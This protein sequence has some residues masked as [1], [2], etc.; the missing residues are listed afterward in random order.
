M[1]DDLLQFG[2]VEY[3]VK[4]SQRLGVL[5][6]GV[7]ILLIWLGMHV[8]FILILGPKGLEE[9]TNFLGAELDRYGGLIGVADVLLFLVLGSSITY[10]AR[11]LWTYR[12]VLDQHG[13]SREG[14]W[15]P[16]DRKI[17]IPYGDIERIT[18]GTRYVLRIIPRQGKVLAINVKILEEAS[19]GLIANLRARVGSGIVNTDLE[20]AILSKQSRDKRE[21]VFVAASIGFLA[22][23]MAGFFIQD[24]ILALFAWQDVVPGRRHVVAFDVGPDGT[25]WALT[26]GK[27]K[28][29]ELGLKLEV[30]GTPGRQ[31]IELP[32]SGLAREVSHPYDPVYNNIEGMAV[33][34]H[35][36]VWVLF[37]ETSKLQY[38]AES[39]WG[40][41]NTAEADA[42]LTRRGIA[43]IGEEVWVIRSEPEGV[44]RIDSESLAVTSFNIHGVRYEGDP[45]VSLYPDT[46]IRGNDGGVVVTGLLNLGYPGIAHFNSEGG[47]VQFFGLDDTVPLPD[48]SWSLIHGGTDGEGRLYAYYFSE[49]GCSGNTLSVI[50]GVREQPDAEWKWGSLGRLLDCSEYWSPPSVAVD[51]HGR[52]WVEVNAPKG[53][54]VMVYEQ[55]MIDAGQSGSVDPIRYYTQKNSHFIGGNLQVTSDGHIFAI[56]PFGGEATWIDASVDELPNPAPQLLVELLD[57]PFLIYIP[58]FTIAVVLT[59]SNVRRNWSR[60]WSAD[61]EGEPSQQFRPNAVSH[62]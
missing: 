14:L 6:G 20:H 10:G 18:R 4:R 9:M 13:I 61:D 21:L 27:L 5:L 34:S 57:K 45:G 43:R 2:R 32:L 39:R 17:R 41:L 31:T 42:Q 53:G 48:T 7:V 54:G 59:A 38:W 47:N 11:Y 58:Y 12:I 28:R 30:I 44:S 40:A 56:E 33:D 26:E 62:D 52:I 29:G 60:D 23:I 16:L 46:M 49:S 51:P 25:V 36:R 1:S 35:N 8:S 15:H 37:E 24:Q 3:R 19:E 22:V 50:A 55:G